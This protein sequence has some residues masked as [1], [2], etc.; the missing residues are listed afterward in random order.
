M[1]CA[2]SRSTGYRA[3]CLCLPAPAC[4]RPLAT[5]MRTATLL[6]QGGR[7]VA[8]VCLAHAP[9]APGTVGVCELTSLSKPQLCLHSTHITV[10]VGAVEHTIT[11]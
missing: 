6:A 5:C 7:E 3:A 11:L 1:L 2:W 10:P 4:P 8:H 9:A